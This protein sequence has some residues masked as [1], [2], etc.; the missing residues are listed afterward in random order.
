VDPLTHG[1]AGALMAKAF[2]TNV[3]AGLQAR[4]DGKPSE[5]QPL[6][7]AMTDAGRSKDRPLPTGEPPDKRAAPLTNHESRITVLIVTLGA[8]FPDADFVFNLFSQSRVATLEYHRWITHSVVCLPVFALG[9]AAATWWWLRRRYGA[10]RVAPLRRLAGMY[11]AGI[12]SHILLD[13]VTSWGTQVW[14]PVTRARANWDWVFILDVTLTAILLLPQLAA[15]LLREPERA[16]ARA[17][18]WWAGMSLGLAGL[19]TAA[20]VVGV[21]FSW[22]LVALGSALLG[23]VLWAA[24]RRSRAEGAAPRGDAGS[25]ARVERRWC[26]AGVV[27]ATAYLALCAA[28]HELALG[29]VRRFVAAHGVAA[30]SVGALPLPPLA[31]RW[32]GLVRTR[33]GVHLALFDL[34]EARPARFEFTADTAPPELLESARE[35]PEVQTYFWFARFPVMRLEERDGWRVLVFN[36]LRFP[37]RW[38][39]APAP[40]EYEVRFDANGKVTAHGWAPLADA[41]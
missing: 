41:E 19:R 18:S 12:A 4:P 16:A 27:A 38:S 36:D 24:V 15:W 10:Q 32:A 26:R 40:F 9:L 11:A 2:F 1:I 37:R 7:P 29:R 33:E 17:M 34:L 39:S 13:A 31:S 25:V 22:T 28:A 20:T 30:E 21:D 8:V 14:A 5:D 3:G 35:L 23:G 6:R